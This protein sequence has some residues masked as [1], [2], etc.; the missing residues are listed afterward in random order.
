MGSLRCWKATYWAFKI[1]KHEYYAVQAYD[2]EEAMEKAKKYG[3][4]NSMTLFGLDYIGDV[5]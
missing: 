3:K 1:D 2:L 5:I 4:P